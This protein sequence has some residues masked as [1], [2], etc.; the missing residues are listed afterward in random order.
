MSIMRM[1]YH[2]KMP[3]FTPYGRGRHM[4][5]DDI[6]NVLKNPPTLVDC[7]FKF[8]SVDDLVSPASYQ[9]A[10]PRLRPV[11]KN[12]SEDL[13]SNGLQGAIKIATAEDVTEYLE[14]END[15]INQQSPTR[16]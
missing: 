13:D 1:E 6:Y 14:D 10:I 8:I 4:L 5:T 3:I 12:V 2:L 16:G 15:I 9:K 11:N 7:N